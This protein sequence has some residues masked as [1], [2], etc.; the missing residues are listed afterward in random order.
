M[1]N[2]NQEQH[3]TDGHPVF[4]PI[5]PIPEHTDIAP[6]YLHHPSDIGS[7]LKALATDGN[8]VTVYPSGSDTF[9]TVRVD[10]VSQQT[11]SLVLEL[12]GGAPA[13][14]GP[15]LFVATPQG[16]KLQFSLDGEWS[17][18]DGDPSLVRS[19]FPK[20]CKILER[21][22]SA[23]FEA[24]LGQY[25]SA[26]FVLDNLL[27]EIPLYDFSSGGVGLRAS[28]AD[29]SALRV[30]RRLS[31]VR[32]ELS[33][34]VVLTVDLEIRLCR[35]FKS[36]LLGEQVQVGCRFVNLTAPMQNELKRALAQFEKGRGR[37]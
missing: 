34:N 25:Y 11:Q 7:V 33:D 1:N 30:G 6:Y 28:P 26:V 15:A 23:R 37:R 36:F 12:V 17:A 32:L 18:V 35:P 14:A 31:K 2:A 9:Q 29:A 16:N 3:R 10:S 13:P 27:Y 8:A 4:R 19:S 22:G 24:P 21:R 20:E 5:E